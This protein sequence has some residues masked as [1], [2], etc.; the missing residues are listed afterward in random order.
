MPTQV[1]D[2]NEDDLGFRFIISRERH[3]EHGLIIHFS[4]SIHGESKMLKSAKVG[5]VTVAN[6]QKIAVL[7][8]QTISGDYREPR[9]IDFSPGARIPHVTRRGKTFYACTIQRLLE[10]AEQCS[11]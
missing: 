5:G 3:P 6:F 4:A 10:R 8:F 2:Y 11:V 9:F 7:I 1:F